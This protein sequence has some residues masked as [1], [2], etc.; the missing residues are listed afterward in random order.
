M[1]LV[2][3]GGISIL[4]SGFA[5]LPEGIACY[6]WQI[7]VNLAWFINVT[8]ISCLDF[9]SHYLYIRPVER[10]VRLI[11]MSASLIILLVA[12]AP[13]GNFNWAGPGR[14]RP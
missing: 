14:E 6:D 11:A 3:A 9:I 7:M 5:Q 2:L 1:D 12:L 8:D 10:R 13:T 4:V